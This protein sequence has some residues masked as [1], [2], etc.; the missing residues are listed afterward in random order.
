MTK[1]AE[2]KDRKG[3]MSSGEANEHFLC[4]AIGALLL[5]SDASVLAAFRGP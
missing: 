4:G 1:G 3:K 2:T 5:F